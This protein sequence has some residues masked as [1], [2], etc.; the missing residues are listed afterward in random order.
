MY[1][2]AYRNTLPIATCVK[3]KEV[4]TADLNIKLLLWTR[5]SLYYYIT[6]AATLLLMNRN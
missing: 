2:R 1:L 4:L 5:I 3:M 6:A